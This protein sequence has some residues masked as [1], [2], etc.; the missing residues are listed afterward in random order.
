MAFIDCSCHYSFYV[1]I[2]TFLLFLDVV[3]FGCCGFFYIVISIF[4]VIKV[5]FVRCCGKDLFNG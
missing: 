2:V 3:P 4:T 5:L 1:C